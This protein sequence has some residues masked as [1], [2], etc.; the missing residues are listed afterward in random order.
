MCLTLKTT[1]SKQ[2]NFVIK[3]EACAS[4]KPHIHNKFGFVNKDEARALP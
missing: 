1:S 2:F 4:S 3:D